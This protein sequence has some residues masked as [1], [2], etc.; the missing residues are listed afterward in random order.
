M[1]RFAAAAL[2]LGR[3]GHAA[4]QIVETPAQTPAGPPAVAPVDPGATGTL[5]A[6]AK[7][8]PG[9]VH[10]APRRGP[11]VRSIRVGPAMQ[12]RPVS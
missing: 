9:G 2:L 10:S 11:A 4:A 3:P 1:M 12:G 7:S 8:G 6:P 5:G